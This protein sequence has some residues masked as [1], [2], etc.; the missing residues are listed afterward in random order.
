MGLERRLAGEVVSGQAWG[1]EFNPY[2][3]HQGQV[4]LQSQCWE[5]RARRIPGAR[6][7]AGPDE[8]P[9]PGSVRDSASNTKEKKES[10]RHPT[11]S[12]CLYTQVHVCLYSTCMHIPTQKHTRVCPVW[13]L[14]ISFYTPRRIKWDK[15]PVKTTKPVYFICTQWAFLSQKTITEGSA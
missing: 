1:S 12:S 11:L 2:L 6:W 5:G 3:P 4:C 13:S 7:P 14:V 9:T 15:S 8:W 10:R